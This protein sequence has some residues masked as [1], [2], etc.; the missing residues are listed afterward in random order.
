MTRKDIP[1]RPKTAPRLMIS[2]ERNMLSPVALMSGF[3]LEGWHSRLRHS[4]SSV[5]VQAV[6]TISYS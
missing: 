1:G 3:E 6:M 5:V 2:R 4:F